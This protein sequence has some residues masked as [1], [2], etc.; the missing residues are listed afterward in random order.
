MGSEG[1]VKKAIIAD[2]LTLTDRFLA[3]MIQNEEMT[4]QQRRE[5]HLV[6]IQRALLE[7]DLKQLENP[8]RRI[9]LVA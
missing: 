4:E 2:T 5:V 7:A 1:R 6:V 9:R 8:S 3:H